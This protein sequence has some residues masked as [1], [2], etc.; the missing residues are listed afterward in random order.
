MEDFKKE[1]FKKPTARARGKLAAKIPDYTG[2]KIFVLQPVGAESKFYYNNDRHV[3]AAAASDTL[4]R[5]DSSTTFV[6]KE[7]DLIVRLIEDT[8]NNITRVFVLSTV[9]NILHDFTITTYPDELTYT[10]K[11]NLNPLILEGFPKIE[12]ITVQLA[13]RD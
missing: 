12:K 8:A 5:R 2:V 9:A 1:L 6:N 11:N 10:F 3:K 7:E 13:Q 4:N